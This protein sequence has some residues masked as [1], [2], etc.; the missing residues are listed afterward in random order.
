[1]TGSRSTRELARRRQARRV[2]ALGFLG[3]IALPL[4]L[5]GRVISEV[6]VGF[7]LDVR[8]LLGWVPWAL[9]TLGL[10]LFVPVLVSI[11]RDP[12]SRL[13]PRAR[14]VYAGWAITLYLL[15]FGLATQ[16]AQLV[17]TGSAAH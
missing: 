1:M 12:C 6:A 5:F 17:T 11:G 10:L 7:H 2:G 3:A 8:Y 9:I 16:V 14:N 15:G 4:L 13:Y